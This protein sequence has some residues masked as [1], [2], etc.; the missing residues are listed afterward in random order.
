VDKWIGFQK[1]S[2][3]CFGTGYCQPLEPLYN[4]GITYPHVI[5]WWIERGWAWMDSGYSHR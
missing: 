5:Q 4:V 2:L 3:N 1:N